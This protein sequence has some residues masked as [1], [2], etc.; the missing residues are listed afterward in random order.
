M[1]IDQLPAL[2]RVSSWGGN[3]RI[4]TASLI[5]M[6]EI[7]AARGTGGRDSAVKARDFFLAAAEACH[8]ASGAS[9][10]VGVVIAE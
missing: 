3:I 2:E 6:V 8:K 7:N 10:H 4:D 1:R 9:G 5:S